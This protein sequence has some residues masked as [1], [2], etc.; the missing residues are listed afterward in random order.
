MP[1]AKLTP[2]RCALCR[3]HD[4]DRRQ[5]PHI[6]QCT[7]PYDPRSP[8]QHQAKC[9]LGIAVKAVTALFDRLRNPQ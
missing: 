5:C 7:C 9:P 1:D 2:G 8:V 4:H 6:H 3:G